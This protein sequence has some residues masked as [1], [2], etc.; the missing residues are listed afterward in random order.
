M[1]VYSSNDCIDFYDID[2]SKSYLPINR[3]KESIKI[4]PNKLVL[5]KGKPKRGDIHIF[6]NLCVRNK[7]KKLETKRQEFLPRLISPK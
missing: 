5:D 4:G 7:R 2:E 1:Y 6:L 3:V